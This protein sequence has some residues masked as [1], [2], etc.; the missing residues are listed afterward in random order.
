MKASEKNTAE[1]Q[2]MPKL[3]TEDIKESLRV[4]LSTEQLLE[5]GKEL[6]ACQSESRQLEDDF[7]SV[8][9]EWKSR[10]S[11]VDAKI[12]TLA[13]R[14]SRGY[15]LRPVS[16]RVT[17]DCPEPGLKTCDRLD[18]MERVWVR[19]MTDND[20]QLAIDFA[21]EQE[22]EEAGAAEGGAREY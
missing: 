20:R 17:F 22:Q 10:I 13:G 8:R 2:P 7:K 4:N 5:C 9:D 11:A 16:C 15:D 3:R 19:E 21:Q 1:E 14:I 12:T 6:A 18:S